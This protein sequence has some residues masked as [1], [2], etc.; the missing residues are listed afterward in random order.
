MQEAVALLSVLDLSAERPEPL[1]RQIYESI[2][3]AILEGRLPPGARLPATRLLAAEAGVGRNTVIAAFEQLAAEGYLDA[4][5]G[6]G[7]RV[8]RL[9]PEA[10]LQA[11]R[12]TSHRSRSAVRSPPAELSRRGRALASI[13]R[14]PHSGPVAFQPGVPALAEF[15][16]PLW[17]RLL[18]RRARHARP[19]TMG[20]SLGAGFPPL[21]KAIAAYVGAA[22]GV[23]CEPEQVVVV[24]GAQ[25]ALDLAARLL[26]DPGDRVW[27]EEPGYLGARGA[28]VAAGAE[29]V[30]VPV[31]EEGLDVPAG[32]RRCRSAR[33]AYV[34]PSQQFPLGRTMSLPRRLELVEWAA[35]A[36]SWILEDDYDSEFRYAG[37]P[38]AALQGL[39]RHGRVVYV[40]TFS[41]TMFPALR[42]GYLVVPAALVDGFATALRNTGHA[43]P[44]AVQAALADFIGEGHFGS[45]VRRMRALYAERGAELVAL[46]RR[47]RGDLLRIPDATGGMQIACELIDS[48][49]D[50]A[51]CERAAARGVSASPLSQYALGLTP[52]RGLHLGFAAVPVGKPMREAAARLCAALAP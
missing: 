17:A 42:V 3:R 29:L 11:E 32:E 22:R 26:V 21:R 1:H 47:D 25:A 10:H 14:S 41:K 16:F 28:L 18:S 52:H 19:D 44:I 7:T 23:L 6:S 5:V 24:A 12:R 15:P 9:S 37:R 46:L 50:V 40:G 43:A 35:R 38:L 33:L 48:R 4:R 13:R 31:D 2:R 30:P 49:D 51:I 34:T 39:D 8:A 20:Y 45:H 27:I 36:G